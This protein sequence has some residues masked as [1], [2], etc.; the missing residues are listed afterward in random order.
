MA[1]EIELDADLGPV[2]RRLEREHRVDPRAGL[3]VSDGVRLYTRGSPRAAKCFRRTFSGPETVSSVRVEVELTGAPRFCSLLGHLSTLVPFLRQIPSV[4][5]RDVPYSIVDRL[6]PQA[7]ASR[8]LRFH[9][10]LLANHLGPGWRR[11]VG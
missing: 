7:D 9:I 4:S 1:Y 2:T 8:T 5:R 10:D 11:K 6:D 3:V